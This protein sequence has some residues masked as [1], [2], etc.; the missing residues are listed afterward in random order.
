MRQPQ[1]AVRILLAIDART[2]A[3]IWK[4][5]S[6][7]LPESNDSNALAPLLWSSAALIANNTVFVGALDRATQPSSW[8]VA[9]D[10]HS[11]A[12]RWRTRFGGGL[13]LPFETTT[14]QLPDPETWLACTRPAYTAGMLLIGDNLGTLAALD[15]ETGQPVWV[16]RYQ[17]RRAV[18][19][20]RFGQSSLRR[21]WRNA[22]IHVSGTRFVVAPEDSNQAFCFFTNPSPVADRPLGHV[23]FVLNNVWERNGL[24]QVLGFNQGVVYFA[25]RDRPEDL[26]VVEA[27]APAGDQRLQPWPSA[28]PL[29]TPIAGALIVGDNWLYVSTDKYVYRI[30]RSSGA[31]SNPLIT[32]E[33]APGQFLGDLFLAKEG[34]L[35][36]APMG[37]SF[38]SHRK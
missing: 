37:L 34:L 36:A 14:G 25:G 3:T 20:S 7:L 4:K 32:H 17:R 9:L 18:N 12:E 24:S 16:Y 29:A 6:R 8:L 27:W 5:E 10:L 28:A 1:S 26:D 11:G 30:D 13:P 38:W 19:T 21:G 22:A 2:G 15:G 23:N 35:I 31:I 33:A